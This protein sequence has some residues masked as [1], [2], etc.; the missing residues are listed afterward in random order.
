MASQPPS[1]SP[2]PDRPVGPEAVELAEL[3]GRVAA[4]ERHEQ[5]PRRRLLALLSAVLITLAAVLT[6]VSV[7]AVWARS[8]LTDTDRYLATVAPLA[9][10]PAVQS[11]VTNAVTDQLVQYLPVDSLLNQLPVADHPLIGPLLNA[12]GGTLTD[13]IAGFVRG[14]VAGVVSSDAFA[15]LWLQ[16]NRAAHDTLDKAL[17]GEGGGAVRVTGNTVTLDLAPLVDQVKA[18]LVSN[19]LGLAAKIPT[20]H[21]QYVLITSDQIGKVRTLLRLLQLAGFWLPVVTVLLAA[22]GVL[23]AG[24]RR[25]ALVTTA[26]AMAAGAGALG[27]GLDLFRPIYLD[28]LPAGVDQAA[29]GAVYDAL[30]RYLHAGV[31]LLLVL[32]ALVALG[33]WLSG[34]GRRARSV[35]ALWRAGIAAVR[36]TAERLGLRLGPVGRFVHRAKAWLC[37]GA[38]L[39]AVVVLLTWSYP[40][41]VVLIWLAVALVA[42]LAV[43]EFLDEP[44]GRGAHPRRGGG[45][46]PLSPPR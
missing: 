22:G 26:L 13:G 24:R 8:Q 27:I 43:V 25:R 9:R 4:L 18:Q 41:G 36:R 29:A 19:G 3:R 21:T 44:G 39:G 30:A 10:D 20:V 40:T 46:S 2:P 23:A 35:R 31:R 34:Y 11:A 14:Q 37:W 1:S 33:A 6:P 15:G 16:A 32:G 42:V 45:A 38:V 28:R 17:T 7:V 12:L 5:P